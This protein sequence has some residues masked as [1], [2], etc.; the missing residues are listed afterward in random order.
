MEPDWTKN[1]PTTWVCNFFYAFFT[2]YAVLTV[3]TLFSFIG[4][5]FMNL[6][7]NQLI[8]AGIQTFLMLGFG[9]TMM[10]F[11]YLIC[12]RALLGSVPGRT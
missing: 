2:V 11:H 8:V 1:I 12:S 6:P 9:G 3:L 10:L 4:L 5:F 7:K